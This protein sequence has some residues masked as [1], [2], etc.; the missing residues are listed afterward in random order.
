MKAF[1]YGLA[2]VFLTAGL[3]FAGR[4]SVAPVS[5]PTL[6]PWGMVGTG[7]AMGLGGLY[8]LFKR[9]K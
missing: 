1:A 6:M 7:V 4:V 2:V 9:N 5:V 3:A 8:F